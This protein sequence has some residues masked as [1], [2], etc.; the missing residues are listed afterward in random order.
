VTE[1]GGIELS[2]CETLDAN[3][4]GARTAC[5]RAGK[6]F[7]ECSRARCTGSECLCEE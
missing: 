3:V 4:A 5:V 2:G 7:K 6:T 1:A